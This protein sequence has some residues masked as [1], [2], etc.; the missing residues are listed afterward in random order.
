M[1][2]SFLR[3]AVVRL[4]CQNKGR[5]E[6]KKVTNPTPS[7]GLEEQ[8]EVWMEILGESTL[9]AECSVL[10]Q[11]PPSDLGLAPPPPKKI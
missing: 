9:A 3:A 1:Q 11:D 4:V 7:C 6:K 5:E 2:P 10:H 8:Q